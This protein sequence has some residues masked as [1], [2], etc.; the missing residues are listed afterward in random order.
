MGVIDKEHLGKMQCY[1]QGLLKANQD[2]PWA[3][4]AVFNGSDVVFFQATRSMR[5][6]DPVEFHLHTPLSMDTGR[7]NT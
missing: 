7:R 6:E 2:R 1:L 4:G 5:E 3:R